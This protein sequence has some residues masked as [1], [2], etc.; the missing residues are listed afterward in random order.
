[1]KRID[2]PLNRWHC[3]NQSLNNQM[4]PHPS[5][6]HPYS[7]NVDMPED[8]EAE[9]YWLQLADFFQ[10]PHITYFDDFQDLERKLIDANFEQIHYLMI[11]EV[12]RKKNKLLLN[13]V[14]EDTIWTDGAP[15]LP[16]CHSNALWCIKTSGYLIAV[17]I[18]L[19]W[20]CSKSAV[21]RMGGV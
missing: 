4:K 6:P 5:S 14:K 9:F 2:P 17:L 16:F 19:Q 3:N 18:L 1:M 11:E 15:R 13:L 12:E 10:W 8:A 7:P 21:V 20:F